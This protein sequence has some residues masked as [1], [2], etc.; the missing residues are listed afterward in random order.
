MEFPVP[1]QL[2][3]LGVPYPQGGTL[4]AL[5]GSFTFSI[6]EST[7]WNRR[8]SFMVTSDRYSF[9]TIS[10]VSGSIMIGPRGVTVFKHLRAAR[11][12]TGSTLTLVGSTDCTIATLGYL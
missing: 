12:A 11:D 8:P 4:S 2:P 1:F 10:R 5:Q 7:F 6:V 9:M 3:T